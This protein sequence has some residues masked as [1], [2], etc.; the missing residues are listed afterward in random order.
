MKFKDK[1]CSMKFLGKGNANKNVNANF[2]EKNSSERRS[3]NPQGAK[4]KRIS[5]KKKKEINEK[6]SLRNLTNLSL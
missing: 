6:E 3:V 5:G 4:R 2:S 1:N